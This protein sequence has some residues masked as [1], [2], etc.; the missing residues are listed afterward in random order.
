MNTT[1]NKHAD[2]TTPLTGR[3][4]SA[5]KESFR[6][7]YDGKEYPAIVRGRFYNESQK[8]RGQFPVVGDYVQF[9]PN[10]NGP[11]R[12]DEICPRKTVFMRPDQRGHTMSFVKNLMG[13]A[14]VAN[15]DYVFFLMS[16]ND[17]FNTNRMVRYISTVLQGGGIPVVVL[18]KSD[19]VADPAPYIAQVQDLSDQVQVCAISG[20]WGIGLE[21]LSPYLTSGTTIAL[22]GSSGVG[23]STLLN[24]IAGKDLMKT[25]AIRESDGKGRHTTTS[26]ELMV[27][28]N[29]VTII[30]TP[31]M[32]ELGICDVEDGLNQIYHDIEELT[33][34]CR[35]NNCSH[36]V[37]PGC[38]IRAAI[39]DGTITEDDWET[40]RDL[41]EESSRNRKMMIRQQ[42]T[43][44]R[45]FDRKRDIADSSRYQ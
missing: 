17:N 40:Y 38:A 11:C 37:E 21:Q 23:K 43:A 35:F 44:T 32:R 7:F 1:N 15:V 2:T 6:I 36:T 20:L 16:M 41:T 4:C 14:M 10:D 30:D 3:I 42:Q 5:Q 39:E 31:G 26:R 25:A 45:G 18:T 8:G 12:I 9:T 27:L 22:M 24:A 28:D 34:Q 19:L 13:Q 29:G 33:H